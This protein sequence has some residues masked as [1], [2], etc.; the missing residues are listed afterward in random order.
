MALGR[1]QATAIPSPAHPQAGRDVT[2]DRKGVRQRVVNG[3]RTDLSK[4]LTD[5]CERKG[6]FSGVTAPAVFQGHTRFATS[7][8]ANG[9]GC[10]PHQWRAPCQQYCVANALK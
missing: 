3:K 9:D 4:L 6:M 8:I 5:K 1:P 2:K 10:H 7:S